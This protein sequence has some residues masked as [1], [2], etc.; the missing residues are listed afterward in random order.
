MSNKNAFKPRPG[1]IV[2]PIYDNWQ[3]NIEIII[4]NDIRNKKIKGPLLNY[5]FSR[6]RIIL[7]DVY[8]S[9]RIYTRVK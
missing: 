8:Y 3:F 4:S 5:V 1:T 6:N 9:S 2:A 7:A